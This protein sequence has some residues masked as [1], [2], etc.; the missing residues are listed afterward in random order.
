[1]N[2]RTRSNYPNGIII[3]F[4]RRKLESKLN[5][6]V[7]CSNVLE[8]FDRLLPKVSDFDHKEQPGVDLDVFVGDATIHDRMSTF[9]SV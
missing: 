2:Y 8:R 9:A 4:A 6:H 1:M 5:I 3:M 7:E